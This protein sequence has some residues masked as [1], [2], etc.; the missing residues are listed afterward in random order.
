MHE[1]KR[2]TNAD[3]TPAIVAAAVAALKELYPKDFGAEKEVEIDGHE[4]VARL[5]RHYHPPGGGLK[6]WGA[7]K[8][9]S[10]FEVVEPPEPT[11]TDVDAIEEP[12]SEESPP[13]KSVFY[14]GKTSNERLIGVHA[15]LVRV[16]R[17]CIGLTPIDFSVIE[18]RR[19]IERQ[20]LLLKRGATQTLQS[21]HLTG[22]AVDLAPFEHGAIHW[23][24]PGFKVLAEA[25]AE[26]ASQE[27]VP[28]EWGGNWKSPPYFKDGPHW[29]LPWAEYK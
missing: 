12:I 21:R 9:I 14:L 13:T 17:R 20:R 2:L 8:G 6:P 11:E 16:V 15:D 27:N 10:M 23:E 19:T 26:A 18:G 3:L 28:V 4:Y 24:W 29:Q 7:H 25:M 22:H 5:E 1:L